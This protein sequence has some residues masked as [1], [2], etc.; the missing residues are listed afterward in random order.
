MKILYV[1]TF[2][3]NHVSDWYRQKAFQKVFEESDTFCYRS[4][5]KRHTIN[6]MLSKLV[7]TATK[8]NYDIIFI[9]KAELID[10]NIITQIKV[11]CPDTL[12]IYWYGDQRGIAVPEFAKLGAVADIM[13]VSNS[14]KNQ[15]EQYKKLGVK[16]IMAHHTGTDTDVFKPIQAIQQTEEHYDAIFLGSNYN[17]RFP[18]SITRKKM[19]KRIN[20]NFKLIV[21]GNNWPNYL[22]RGGLVYKD[23]Y[24]VAVSNAKIT[25]GINAYNN[26]NGYTSNRM[27]NCLACGKPHLACYYDGIENM[28]ENWKHLIW[29]KDS[30]EALKIIKKLLKDKKMR[31]EIGMNGRQYVVNKHSYLCRAEEIKNIYKEWK[32]EKT[33]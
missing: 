18:E 10:P 23:A 15:F 29:F 8:K 12:I 6:G 20:N 19:I 22:A 32:D 13:L 25:L 30:D 31:E 3:G 21:Y 26:I 17:V 7:I 28:F 33:K 16:K 14:D 9:N 2:V 5:A 24:A 4:S 11:H 1:G 27:W